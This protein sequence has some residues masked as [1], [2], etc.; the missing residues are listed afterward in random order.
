M[1]E[2]GLEELVSALRVAGCVFAEE[3]AKILVGS[4][5]NPAELVEMLRRRVAGEPLEHVVGWVWFCGR[6]IAVGPGVFVPRRRTEFLVACAAAL[7]PPALLDLCCGS[8]AIGLSVPGVTELHAADVDAAAVE[9]AARNLVA[10]GGTVHRGD[11]FDALPS[12]LH[13]RFDA[14]V[15]NA[16][17]VPTGEIELM[18]REARIHEPNVALDGGTDGAGLHRRVAAQA[19]QWLAPNGS[20]LIETSAQLVGSTLQ[21]FL[22]AG[23]AAVVRTSETLDAVVVIGSAAEQ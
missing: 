5:T 3:E 14:I 6:R 4:A 9:C 17:Y 22:E 7:H 20:V 21:A 11:L 12:E 18:P 23:L 15:V 1:A 8:G 13:R 2:P 19:L 10:V 16:P